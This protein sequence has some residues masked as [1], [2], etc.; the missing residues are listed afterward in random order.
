MLPALVLLRM[1]GHANVFWFV[2]AWGATAGVGA[3]VGPLQARVMPRLSG[4]WK[5]LTQHRDLG[6]RYLVEGT[7]TSAASQL[8]NYGVGLILGLAA[9]GYLQAANTLMGPFQVILYGMGLVALPEAARILRR[10]PRHMALFCVLLS[11]ALTLLALAWGVALLVALPRGLGDKLLG[12]IWRPAY[13]L[14]LPTALFMAGGCASSGAGTWLHALGAARRSMRASALT[15]VLYLALALA[16]AVTGG[17]VG[18]IRG[19]ALGTWIGSLLYWWQV[20]AARRESRNAPTEDPSS[21]SL[22]NGQHGALPEPAR[23]LPLDLTV[24]PDPVARSAA[25]TPVAAEWSS[26]PTPARVCGSAS[27]RRHRGD[28]LGT[29]R[30][31]ARPCTV[32]SRRSVRR[33]RGGH[34][35]PLWPVRTLRT[36]RCGAQHR[37]NRPSHSG[38]SHPGAKRCPT[39][40]RGSV[41]A[42]YGAGLG[43]AWGLLVLNAL[44]YTGALVHIPSAFGKGITQGALPLALIVA[45]SVN[46]KVVLRP[47][48]FLCLALLLVIEAFVPILQPQHFGTVLPGLPARRVRGRALAADA[49]VGPTRPAARPL[50]SDIALGD[51]GL[52]RARRADRARPRPGC[53]EAQRRALGYPAHPGRAL[54]RGH[55]GLVVVLW[56]CGRLRGRP[57]LLIVAVTGSVLLLTHTRTALVGMIAGLLVAGLSLIVASARVRKLFAASGSRDGDRDHDTLERHRHLSGPRSGHT[58]ADQPHRPYRGLERPG[59]L[60]PR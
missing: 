31:T 19:A 30:G 28:T 21:A 49:V 6:F 52:G 55:P 50:P 59:E 20:R 38:Q 10:S 17:T 26:P 44:G 60:S 25:F 15:A 32:G 58:A 12:P 23:R 24:P 37:R 11:V 9:V 18:T 4:S 27:S 35:C 41:N 53:G 5:W 2:F 22:Q 39:R 8:R 29:C 43:L 33:P 46:R 48:V 56:V 45:L 36:H 42:G 34:C 51:P 54:C 3:A 40:R 13:P 47:N 14:V 57:T 16:G 1:T 7:A